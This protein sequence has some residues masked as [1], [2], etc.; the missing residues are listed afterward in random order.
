MKHR[1][2]IS[3]GTNLGSREDNLHNAIEHLGNHP[4]IEVKDISSIYET[5]PVGLEEQP[6]FLNMALKL[7][8]YLNA[9]ELLDALA[10]IEAKMGR[11]RHRIW[12]PRIIDLDL[13]FFDEETIV[14]QDLIVPHPR[15]LERA[16]VLIPL[17]EL[18][19]QLIHPRDGVPLKDAAQ[20][21]NI[22]KQGVK[23]FKKRPQSR[24]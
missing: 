11:I 17:L 7:D 22:V 19:P 13:L 20:E 14:T 2:Y 3:L 15:I 18:D 24:G 8:T 16:F 9:Q 1:A 4:D 5:L 6:S 21:P 12:G 23:M 10:D